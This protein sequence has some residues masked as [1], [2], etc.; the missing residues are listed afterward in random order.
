MY[1]RLYEDGVCIVEDFFDDPKEKGHADYPPPLFECQDEQ[2]T[3]IT[4]RGISRDIIFDGVRRSCTT[5]GYEPEFAEEI[6]K[7]NKRKIAGPVQRQQLKPCKVVHPNNQPMRT[8][9]NAAS[10]FVIGERG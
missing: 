6:H 9:I 4:K 1:R 3:F 10:S 5:Y 7:N 8:A 2:A